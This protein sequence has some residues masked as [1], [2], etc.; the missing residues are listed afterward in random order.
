MRSDGAGGSLDETDDRSPMSRR[1]SAA[2]P[3]YPVLVEGTPMPRADECPEVAQGADPL[4]RRS[5]SA[6]AAGA[7]TSPSWPG[8]LRSTFPRPPRGS[9]SGWNSAGVAGCSAMALTLSVVIDQ[10][11]AASAPL[12]EPAACR[13]GV[14][15]SSS[16]RGK[17]ARRG[18]RGPLLCRPPAQWFAPSARLGRGW[19]FLVVVPASAAAVRVRSRDRE[20]AAAAISGRRRGPAIGTFSAFMLFKPVCR[21]TEPRPPACWSPR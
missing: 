9:C 15:A 14:S 13:N 18:R 10:P 19:I 6:T 2:V 3:V 12:P 1:R 16:R 17:A 5:R 8:S 4:L 20:P 11:L 7:K 21:N